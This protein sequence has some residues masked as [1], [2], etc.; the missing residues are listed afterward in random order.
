MD[1]K[2]SQNL[3][4]QYW[5]QKLNLNKHPEGGYF[6]ETYRSKELISAEFL[7]ERYNG[8]R[9]FSTSIYFLLESEDIS[10]FH[11]IKSDEVW[12]FYYGSSITIFSI[13]PDGMLFKIKLGTDLENGELFQAHLKAGNWFGAKVTDPDSFA[14]VGCTV[15][16]GFEFKDFELGNR[17]T[18]L[19]LFPRHSEVIK[20]LTRE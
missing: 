3:K 5:I 1:K 18:L 7:P 11:R 10:A 2:K 13:D 6:R 12:H 4:A 16:P 9:C 19:N 17:K 8:D 20:L 14:L 15:A